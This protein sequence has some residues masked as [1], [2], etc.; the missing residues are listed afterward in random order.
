[1]NR[2]G[3]DQLP[4]GKWRCRYVDS[5]GK[6]HSKTFDAYRDAKNWRNSQLASVT[7]G[8]HVALVSGTVMF[9]DFA[10]QRMLAWRSHRDTTK[11]QV[12]SHYKVHLEPF[13]GKRPLG[14]ITHSE[15]EAWVSHRQDAIAVSTLH[16]VTSWL[17]RIFADAVRL[18]LITS[19]PV[20]GVALPQIV[21]AEVVPF[22]LDQA[23]QLADAMPERWRCAV[24]VSMWAGLRQGE[25]LGLRKHRLDLLGRRDVNGQR[26]HPTL[27]VREQL[28]TLSTGTVLV[29]PKTPKSVR[30]VPLPPYL[31]DELAAH[32]ARFPADGPEGFIFTTPRTRQ[33]PGGLPIRRT[34]FGEAWRDAV[35][36][37]GMPKGTVFHRLRH[38]YASLLI[39]AGESVVAVSNRLGHASPM[40]TLETYAHLWPDHFDRT[41]DVLTKAHEAHF[42]AIGHAIGHS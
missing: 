9:G 12:A 5:D 19:S 7:A 40:E 42:R 36:E 38:T 35:T 8:T 25:V 4:S 11:A 39:E 18:R 3:I 37:A 10:D 28:Q 32:L 17:R 21:K 30:K 20:D 22:T 41:V 34:R 23:Y 15:V 13:F 24:L 6:R 31:V 29:P 33:T 14:K 2:D 27:F 1:M 26:Q 16:V